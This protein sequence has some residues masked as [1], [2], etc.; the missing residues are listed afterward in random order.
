MPNFSASD[1]KRLRD[2]T[3]AGMMD[4]KKALDEADGDF[5]AATDIL[6]TT[7][8]AKAA[9][10]GAERTAS[11]GLV[12][13]SAG[14]LVELKC[15]TDFVAKGERF[16]QLGAALVGA[17][18]SSEVTDAEGLLAADAGGRKAAELIEENSAALGEKIEL[19]RVA[20]LTGP[21]VVSYLHKTS[22]DLPP[23]LGVLVALSAENAQVGKD[24]AQHIAAFAPSY[25]SRDDVPADVVENERRIAEA[26]AREEGKPESA[27]PRIVEGRVNGFFK[28]TVL[29][30]QA[31]AKD[32][33][34]SVKQVLDEA[35]VQ[36]LPFA[37]FRVGQS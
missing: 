36:V 3:G 27:L 22:P 35:G 21:H 26:T 13:H 9:K 24:V 23:Q 31:F 14:V 12:A 11:A 20:K 16:Q 6:R 10:R 1:V 4:A 15:E 30:E 29:V 19:G 34:K 8:A 33:K 28:D 37:R 7:G 2:M 5:V 32:N 25:L 18:A 17:F